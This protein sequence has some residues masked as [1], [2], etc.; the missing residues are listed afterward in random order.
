MGHIPKPRSDSSFYNDRSSPSFHRLDSEMTDDERPSSAFASSMDQPRRK[1]GRSNEGLVIDR[2]PHQ[3]REEF[4]S[5]ADLSSPPPTHPNQ[6]VDLN[7]P[8]SVI[9]LSSTITP[10]SEPSPSS[11]YLPR[12]LSIRSFSMSPLTSREPYPRLSTLTLTLGTRWIVRAHQTKNGS[13]G[14]KKR[15]IGCLLNAPRLV[16]RSPADGASGPPPPV[17][18]RC[19]LPPS[20]PPPPP[21]PRRRPLLRILVRLPSPSAMAGFRRESRR[22]DDMY[23]TPLSAEI[24]RGSMQRESDHDG[25]PTIYRRHHIPNDGGEKKFRRAND[26]AV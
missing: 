9:T 22:D 11:H 25:P 10:L 26:R 7:T 1:R 8:A 23:F 12:S 16:A 4:F 15:W 17:P 21:P 2:T 6:V 3:L 13:G 20:P 14:R 5:T 24:P 19:S 18:Y